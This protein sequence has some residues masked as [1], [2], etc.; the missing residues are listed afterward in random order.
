MVLSRD[1]GK[2]PVL[3]ISAVVFTTL[4][5]STDLTPSQQSQH[6]VTQLLLDGQQQ[7]TGELGAEPNLTAT[8]ASVKYNRKQEDAAIVQNNIN[9]KGASVK[10]SM[11]AKEIPVKHNLNAEINPVQYNM[12]TCGESSY[13]RGPNQKIVSF[14]FFKQNITS[15]SDGVRQ[16]FAG[17][18]AN[19]LLMSEL[20]PGFVMRLYYDVDS[21]TELELNRLKANTPNLDLCPADN[22]PRLGNMARLYPLI[23]RFLPSLDPQVSLFL[24][25]DLDSRLSAR[26]AAAVNQ[27]LRSDRMVHVMR[28]NPNHSASMMG[29]MWGARLDPTTRQQFKSSFR[30]MFKDGLSYAARAS[31]GWDQAVL[32]R[33]VWPWAKKTLMSHDSYTCNQFSGTRAFPT[34]RLKGVGNYVGSIISLKATVKNKCPFKCRPKEHPD[35]SYC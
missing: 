11:K 30:R 4:F 19:L 16:Y 31:G 29:G 17:I 24:S 6:A 14:T 35:W 10:Y 21:D 18:S 9:S 25:R 23:W 34:Q 20:Y 28:D 12:T 3:V 26:E 8:G 13:A 15:K 2:K 27:F 7:R 1:L 5:Y 22:N 32:K 33:Y